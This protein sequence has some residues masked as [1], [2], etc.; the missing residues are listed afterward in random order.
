MDRAEWT[1]AGYC[2]RSRCGR[3]RISQAYVGGD[4]IHTAWRQVPGEDGQTWQAFLYTG[5]LETAQ[6][7]CE[8]DST[9]DDFTCRR[10]EHERI[11]TT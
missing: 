7:A 5:E 4:W 9:Q 2:W 10:D 3:Y 11:S 6:T 8:S 1:R